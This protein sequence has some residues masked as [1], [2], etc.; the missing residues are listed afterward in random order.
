[1]IFLKQLPYRNFLK[2][3]KT[4]FSS[5]KNVRVEREMSWGHMV[6]NTPLDPFLNV[7]VIGADVQRIG[8]GVVWRQGSAPVS[9]VPRI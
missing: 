8:A 7:I 5:L 3:K 2:K 6:L 1:M 4:S 9:S